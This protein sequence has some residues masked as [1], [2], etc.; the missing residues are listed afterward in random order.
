MKYVRYRT[1][2]GGSYTGILSRDEKIISLG[3]L[4]P[5]WMG[6][7]MISIML[8]LQDDPDMEKTL[9]TAAEEDAGGTGI[10]LDQVQLLSPIERPLHDVICVGVNYADHLRETKES[11]DKNF[12]E[13]PAAVYFSKRANRITGSGETVRGIFETDSCLDYEVE[14]AVIIGK[15]GKDIPREHAAEHIFGYSI[16]NDF[17]SRTLQARHNQ[18][19][20][21]KSPDGYTA[22][23][24]WIVSAD[25]IAWP[26]RLD[27]KSFVNG[28][29]RQN[30]NTQYFIHSI[31]EMIEDLSA[32]FEL[33]CGDIIAT[34]TPSGVGM[35]FHPP[36]YLKAGDEVI[37]EISE[38][39]SL[40]NPVI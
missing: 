29:L 22:M 38:I 11:F 31:A 24:P 37:C 36:R 15:G 25:E 12:V 20:L 9:R 13:P 6:L 21:G 27:V 10:P 18:W 2:D 8:L 40:R 17:S 32:C 26:P 39:G 33:E 4:N 23:G 5:E 16:F 30:S 28:E 1:A 35:G 3:Q 34:G 19:Y 14:L 7:D